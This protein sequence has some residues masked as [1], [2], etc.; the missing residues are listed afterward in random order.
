[1]IMMHFR[2]TSVTAICEAQN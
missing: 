2:S 1:M